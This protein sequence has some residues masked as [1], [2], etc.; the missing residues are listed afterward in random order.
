MFWLGLYCEGLMTEGL[1]GQAVCNINYNIK[2]IW[3]CMTVKINKCPLG[4]CDF[5]R[6]ELKEC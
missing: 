2:S 4:K 1:E 5:K 6:L 3:I